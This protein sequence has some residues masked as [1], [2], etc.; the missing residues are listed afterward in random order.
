MVIT[1]NKIQNNKTM[2]RVSAELEGNCKMK[3]LKN[4]QPNDI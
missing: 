4:E 1:E 3:D 2:T